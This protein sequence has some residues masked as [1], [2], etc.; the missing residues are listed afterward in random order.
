MEFEMLRLRHKHEMNIKSCSNFET[1]ADGFD[2]TLQ[3]FELTLI[4][5]RSLNLTPIYTESD[6]I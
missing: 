1:R 3:I 4:C 6:L 5:V 2:L